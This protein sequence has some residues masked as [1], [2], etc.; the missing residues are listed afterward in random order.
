MQLNNPRIQPPLFLVRFVYDIFGIFIDI[1]NADI[2][3]TEYKKLR[4][5]YIKLTSSISSVRSDV[6]DVS[7][8]KGDNFLITAQLQTKLYQNH[9]TGSYLN[10]HLVP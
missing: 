5:G 2:F 8:Y 9:T 4:P 10:P 7:I 3:L 6:L 1:Y